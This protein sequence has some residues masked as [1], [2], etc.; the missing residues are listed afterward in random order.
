MAVTFMKRYK[1]SLSD[2]ILA[3]ECLGISVKSG[4]LWTRIKNGAIIYSGFLG[5]MLE[6]SIDTAASMRARSYS[7]KNVI[8]NPHKFGIN[9]LVLLLMII[10]EIILIIL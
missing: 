7:G 3:Q 5:F 1:I 4:S 2:T 6:N 10:P 8:Y 9:D